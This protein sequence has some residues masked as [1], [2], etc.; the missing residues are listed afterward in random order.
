[1]TGR[2]S[3]LAVAVTTSVGLAVVVGL[4]V[5]Q[6][7]QTIAEILGQVG[8]RILWLGPL[9]VVPL[10]LAA[11]AWRVMFVGRAPPSSVLVGARW[12]GFSVNQLLPV[13]RVGGEV[14][15]GR[16]ASLGSRSQIRPAEAFAAVVADKTAVVASIVTYA[17]IGL[18]LLLMYRVDASTAWTAGVGALLLAAG[19]VGFYSAQ[20]RGLISFLGRGLKMLVPQ[21]RKEGTQVGADRVQEELSRVYDEPWRLW[22]GVFLHVLFRLGLS[23]E[24]YLA[25]AWTG[26]PVPFWQAAVIESLTQV[27]RAAAFMIPGALGAQEGSFI[28]LGALFGIPAP[29]GLSVSLCKRARELMVGI[30]GLIVWQVWEGRGLFKGRKGSAAPQA[31]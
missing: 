14:V 4:S 19:G 13:A 12:V 8:H 17:C 10:L 30:P 18:G 1:M 11:F 20:R 26:H 28:L 2:S 31:S 25:L 3:S 6:G 15:R 5:W 9:W 24:V 27:L 16:L 29:V 7:L 22:T 21:G 23:L